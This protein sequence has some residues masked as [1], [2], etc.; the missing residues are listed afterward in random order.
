LLSV[1]PETFSSQRTQR[2]QRKTEKY[3]SRSEVHSIPTSFD[4]SIIFE[5]IFLPSLAFWALNTSGKLKINKR[6][7]ALKKLT[8]KDAE[9]AKEN[10]KVFL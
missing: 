6:N 5:P 4:P 2:T 9:D 7:S 3:F 10:R 1:R 8:A